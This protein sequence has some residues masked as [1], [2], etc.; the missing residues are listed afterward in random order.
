MFK[1]LFFSAL[2][3]FGA[4]ALAEMQGS[5]EMPM[6]EM[7][8]MADMPEDA[9]GFNGSVEL[10]YKQAIGDEMDL[11]TF[12]YRARAGWT[13]SVNEYVKW[14]VGVSSAIEEDFSGYQ[15]KAINLEQAYVKVTPVEG[16]WVKA[17]K[18]TKKTGPHYTGVLYDDDWYEEGVS[19]K[20]KADVGDGAKVYVKASVVYN[21]EGQKAAVDQVAD[22]AAATGNEAVA[23]AAKTAA[24]AAKYGPFTE[25]ALMEAK[26][27]AAFDMGMAQIHGGV[28][29]QSDA[30]ADG[31]DAVNLGQV[32][33]D[34]GSDDVADSG[35]GLG[36]YGVAG[37][38]FDDVGETDNWTYTAGAYVGSKEANE[39]N[40]YSV[41][42]SYYNVAGASWNTALVDTDY[43]GKADGNGIAARAQYNVWDNVS[44][45]A[46]YAYAMKQ[47]TAED[48]Q[49]AVGEVTFNF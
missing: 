27:G 39:A 46:K 5:S 4:Q 9:G 35:V 37:V 23:E 43:I 28:G 32:Y 24:A 8:E 17:G 2:L 33:L 44:V 13:G 29:V 45:V 18:S 22:V 11:G 10:K 16:F 34:F 7:Q 26:A 38:N 41:T 47:G 36:A 30:L 40:D 48:V 19:A 14:G 25:G 15:W 1:K 31:K 12:H 6:Q 49:Q 42:V 3:V 20:F 21:G